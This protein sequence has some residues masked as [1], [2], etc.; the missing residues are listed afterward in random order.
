MSQENVEAARRSFEAFN[1]T[2]REGTHDLYETLDPEVEWVP[3][4]ALLMRTSYHGH[5][6]VRQWIEEMKRDW[7]TFEVRPERFVDV[8]DEGVLV[9]GAWRAQG[10][11]GEALLDIP[12]AAWLVEYRKGLLVRL[13]TFTDRKEALEAAGLRE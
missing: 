13:R 7:T 10:R 3:M 4:S 1:R 9:L 8:G 2:F 6:G 5:D 11:K 12:Q